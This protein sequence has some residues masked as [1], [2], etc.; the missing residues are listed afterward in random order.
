MAAKPTPKERTYNPYIFR[1]W[2]QIYWHIQDF[3]YGS[4]PLRS[5]PKWWVAAALLGIGGFWVAAWFA[6]RRLREDL[7]RRRQG[8]PESETMGPMR[9]TAVDLLRSFTATS[10]STLD[11]PGDGQHKI[12][13]LRMPKVY[14]T[15]DRAV[16]PSFATDRM[17]IASLSVKQPDIQIERSY[18]PLQGPHEIRAAGQADFVIKKY[19]QGEMGRYLHSKRPGQDL[20]E[21]RGYE[22]TWDEKW[23]PSA[24]DGPL[25][26]VV[27]IVG[28]T[29][30][31]PAYQLI[32]STLS[33][34]AAATSP[35]STSTPK[36]RLL[37]A[38]ASPSSFLLLPELKALQESHPDRLQIGLFVE[39]DETPA[40]DGLGLGRVLGLGGQRSVGGFKATTGRIGQRDIANALS[41]SSP[42]T[43]RRA[44]LVC[45]P[46]GMVDAIAGP[47]SADG[48][49]QGPLGGVLA[50]IEGVKR[51]EVWKL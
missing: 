17:V 44:I 29:G 50:K 25:E 2:Q 3:D 18:S 19:D 13:T 12:L 11:E 40:A 16:D 33:K 24:R 42:D 30:V 7:H 6:P 46:N 21:I 22:Q 48:R 51:G 38:A 23:M 49:S 10:P 4:S 34:A 14:L 35:T 9:W 39:R 36:F 45:G 27:F 32:N 37:Y 28:G 31:A 1:G 15:G 5:T 20:V 47:R 8:I 41:A 43:P 26:E